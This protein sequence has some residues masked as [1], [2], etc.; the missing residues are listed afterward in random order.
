MHTKDNIL[1]RLPKMVPTLLQVGLWKK[2]ILNNRTGFVLLFWFNLGGFC[3][4]FFI[5]ENSSCCFPF[6]SV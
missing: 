3:S 2:P 1:H 5:C 4:R 6:L